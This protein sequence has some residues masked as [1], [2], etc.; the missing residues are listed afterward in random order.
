M[1]TCYVCL[2]T[3]GDSSSANDSRSTIAVEVVGD[4]DTSDALSER[5][6]EGSDSHQSLENRGD[7]LKNN[8]SE[9]MSYVQNMGEEEEEEEDDD[10]EL[11]ANQVSFGKVKETNK[12]GFKM[13]S[14]HR[15]AVQRKITL[16]DV[17]AIFNEETLNKS[18]SELEKYRDMLQN[19]K[20]ST[21]RWCRWRWKKIILDRAIELKLR[22][23]N[24]DPGKVPDKVVSSFTQLANVWKHAGESQGKLDDRKHL[25]EV[26]KVMYDCCYGCSDRNPNL[27][28]DL[29]AEF[30]NQ[31]NLAYKGIHTDRR[32]CIA[33]T[34]S[35]V[36]SDIMQAIN[37][38]ARESHGKQIRCKRTKRELQDEM[39]RTNTIKRRKKGPRVASIIDL[40][41]DSEN[42]DV[43]FV[44]N[45]VPSKSNAGTETKF[46]S[47]MTK[48]R[49]SS[50]QQ[51]QQGTDSR[52]MEMLQ[53]M[54]AQLKE[55]REQLRQSE[56]E[57]KK[58]RE[59]S[60]KERIDHEKAARRSQDD[61]MEIHAKKIQQV[62][63][64]EVRSAQ[65]KKQT[66]AICNKNKTKRITSKKD[67]ALY[68]SDTRA[69]TVEKE[70]KEEDDSSVAST[71]LLDYEV[72]SH[73]DLSTKG[74]EDDDEDSIEKVI[75]HKVEKKELMLKVKWKQEDSASWARMVDIWV[76]DEASVIKYV[77]D[78]SF[79]KQ[80]GFKFFQFV[81]KKL[82][83][84]KKTDLARISWMEWKK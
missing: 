22:S 57:N 76:D 45:M 41:V 11:K 72:G 81:D 54:Q 73:D 13:I 40:T 20:D 38:P 58:L 78:S 71:N 51:V 44:T 42:S 27:V 75:D 7:S 15:F 52:V 25:K 23:Y 19:E 12:E 30:M 16:D 1:V 6:E 55:S 67:G 9:D 77:M 83:R 39:K 8:E 43:G 21:R 17:R 49:D 74:D 69:T 5:N 63:Q 24:P 46:E 50:G 28:D 31:F 2:Q 34:L 70:E 48:H 47:K 4:D 35:A 79:S 61:K 68:K 37:R 3:T 10:A 14:R 36:R 66:T 32:G 80:R 59:A 26:Y 65:M 29:E 18:N 56:Y 33:K 82:S 53:E 64:K 60:K 62:I 84:R